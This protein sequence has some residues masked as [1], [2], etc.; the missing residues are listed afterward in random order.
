MSY[1]VYRTVI[2]PVT[3]RCKACGAQWPEMLSG[4]LSAVR[5][6]HDTAEDHPQD[7]YGI[8]VVSIGPAEIV[9]AEAPAL[10]KGEDDEPDYF[11][12]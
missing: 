3:F 1:S 5:C 4:N 10:P 6:P 2:V 9:P 8:G 12:T 11:P 7:E